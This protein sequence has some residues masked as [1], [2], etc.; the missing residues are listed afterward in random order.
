MKDS[1]EKCL[2][3]SQDMIKSNPFRIV[4]RLMSA[5]L[6]EN[7]QGPQESCKEN[8]CNDQMQAIKFKLTRKTLSSLP[9]RL[10]NVDRTVTEESSQDESDEFS[11]R[12][13]THE[14]LVE[15]SNFS[16]EMP[17]LKELRISTTVEQ[18]NSDETI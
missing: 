6:E 15:D 3:S 14:M 1:K 13:T 5:P 18:K 10:K 4:P 8:E 11:E 2:K 12:K 7:K 16:S 17:N 9:Y